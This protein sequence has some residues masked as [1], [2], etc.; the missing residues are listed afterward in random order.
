MTT[1]PP[2]ARRSTDLEL[3]G[4]HLRLG[5]LALARAELETLA[6]RDA[7]D[8]AGLVDLAEARWR[9]GDVAGA[10]EAA[11]AVLGDD[12]DRD[13]D[14]DGPLLALVVAAEAA[15]ARGRPTESRRLAGRAMAVAG[16]TIDAVF[17]GMPRAQVW[18]ADPAALPH[19][20][21]TLFDMPGL[22]PSTAILD[23]AAPAH[24]TAPAAE[25]ASMGLWDADGDELAEADA[26]G[27]IAE[28]PAADG[29]LERGRVAMAAGQT[30]VAAVHLGL[31]LRVSPA[32]APAVLDVLADDRSADLAFVR[33][34]AYRL[35]GHEL[36]ARRAFAQALRPST[37]PLPAPGS[38]ALP[39]DPPSEGVPA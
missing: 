8:D 38:D 21:A 37:E 1:T 6:G 10:G 3:A 27:D 30:S 34:D 7:L 4:L 11:Q 39:D 28:L 35:V 18:P 9:T 25:L 23:L 32:L 29:E 17:A 33:G 22:G 24:S 15:M 20:A 5:A 26:S 16:G 19:V 12:V 13:D 14:E 36:D 31:V 2:T